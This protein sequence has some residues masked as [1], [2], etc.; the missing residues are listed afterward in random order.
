MRRTLPAAAPYQE[1]QR[2]IQRSALHRSQRPLPHHPQRGRAFTNARNAERSDA[3]P[4]RGPQGELVTPAPQRA[5][6]P[7]PMAA[8][9]SGDMR[10][11]FDSLAFASAANRRR[12]VKGRAAAQLQAVSAEPPR[13]KST[14]FWRNQPCFCLCFGFWQMTIT[15]PLRRMILHFSQIGFTDG[16]TFMVILTSIKLIGGQRHPGHRMPPPAPSRRLRQD[17]FSLGSPG[18]PTAGQVVWRHLYRDL[19]A[20]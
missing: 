15:R 19:V 8:I 12:A 4:K 6:N 17:G 7:P 9:K 3:K 1:S 20:R 16:F 13:Q 5:W 18:D 11:G 10:V 14:D 2:H